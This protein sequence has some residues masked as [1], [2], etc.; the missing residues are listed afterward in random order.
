MDNVYHDPDTIIDD[1]GSISLGLIPYISF[2]EGIREQKKFILKNLD[3][4]IEDNN[5]N[6]AKESSIA[7]N[8]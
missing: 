3:K 7:N 5:L 1:I 2:F 4:Q 6:N 8:K